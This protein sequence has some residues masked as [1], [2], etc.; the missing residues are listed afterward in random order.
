MLTEQIVSVPLI[1]AFRG[2]EAGITNAVEL[3]F[4]VVLCYCGCL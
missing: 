2:H 1:L 3:L 4:P